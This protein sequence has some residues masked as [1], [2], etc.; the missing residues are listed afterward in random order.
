MNCSETKRSKSK[1]KRIFWL[2][3]HANL[4]TTPLFQV[5]KSIVLLVEIS[6]V[7]VGFPGILAKCHLFPMICYKLCPT[8]LPPFSSSVVLSTKTIHKSFP[9]WFLHANDKNHKQ[10]LMILRAGSNCNPLCVRVVLLGQYLFPKCLIKA[11]F[12]LNWNSSNSEQIN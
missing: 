12:W 5:L 6:C 4:A 3:C 11:Y 8:P 7:L 9:N 1:Q 2:F 10:I